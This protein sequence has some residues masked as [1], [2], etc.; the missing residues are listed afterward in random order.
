MPFRST[1]PHAAGGGARGSRTA[2]RSPSSALPGIRVP[3]RVQRRQAGDRRQVHHEA[4]HPR[5][6]RQLLQLHGPARAA[7][8]RDRCRRPSPALCIRA[9]FFRISV[10]TESGFARTMKNGLGLSAAIVCPARPSG[11]D[12][13]L[14]PCRATRPSRRERSSAPCSVRFVVVTP[15]YAQLATRAERGRQPPPAG[16]LARQVAPPSFEYRSATSTRQMRTSSDIDHVTSWRS[17]LARLR[18]QPVLAPARGD[19]R[20]RR[21]RRVGHRQRRRRRGRHRARTRTRHAMHPVLRARVRG[22]HRGRGVG[23]PR[24]AL[25]C[26]ASRWPASLCHWSR[27]PPASHR[28]V[29]GWLSATVWLS[30]AS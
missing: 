7:S 19:H 12:P 2:P 15:G 27:A 29:A 3:G 18:Q 10:R 17:R 20:C 8:A 9:V 24:R 6:V 16:R 14:A 13:H 21:R 30:A 23:R 11:P 4:Q 1:P 5:V 22:L 26:P 25:R 28:N